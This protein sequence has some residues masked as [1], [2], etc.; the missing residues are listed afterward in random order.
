MQMQRLENAV[1]HL[2]VILKEIRD[3]TGA[4]GLGVDGIEIDRPYV[5]VRAEAMLEMPVDKIVV[6][7]DDTNFP[8]ELQATL[9]NI[10]FLAL[11]TADEYKSW[12][13]ELQ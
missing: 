11:L 12:K 7:R 4:I 13:Q 10:K 1:Q 8:Y 2:E 3:V 5:Q 9:G 6:E